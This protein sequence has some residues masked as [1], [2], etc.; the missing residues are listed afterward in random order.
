MGGIDE[1]TDLGFIS[2]QHVFKARGSVLAAR[3]STLITQQPVFEARLR[4]AIVCWSFLRCRARSKHDVV[5]WKGPLYRT[6]SDRCGYRLSLIL[7]AACCLCGCFVLLPASRLRFSCIPQHCWPG[8]ATI[9]LLRLPSPT[10]PT[11]SPSPTCYHTLSVSQRPHARRH[12]LCA[13][14]CEVNSPC[15][16]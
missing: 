1:V 9:L 14:F 6:L 3:H 16:Q 11:P 12:R 15:E 7:A 2:K 8:L 13:K 10:T 5:S 4:N